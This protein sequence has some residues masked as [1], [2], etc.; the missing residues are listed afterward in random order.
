[1][2]RQQRAGSRQ[3]EKCECA[4]LKEWIALY[5]EGEASGEIRQQLL[6]HIQ[7][8]GMCA[9]FVRSLKRVVHYCQIEPGWDVPQRAHERLWQAI[10]ELEEL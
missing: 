6:L 8:C 3:P 9:R 10:E 5:I 4:E 1:M 2:S 7:S